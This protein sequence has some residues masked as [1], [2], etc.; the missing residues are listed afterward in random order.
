MVGDLCG[1]PSIPS[2]K[3]RDAHG[4]VILHFMMRPGCMTPM[5]Q[6]PTP[7]LAVP[8]AAPRSV[9]DGLGLET[10]APALSS[11][12]GP[13]PCTSVDRCSSQSLLL[14]CMHQQ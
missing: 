2:I 13:S 10:A 4:S 11:T 6:M 12:K 1:A 3:N 8:Y 9:G 7:D 5:E 14:C